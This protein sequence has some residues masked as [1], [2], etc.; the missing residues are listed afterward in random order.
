MISRH[1]WDEITE[2]P[3]SIDI[4]TT[5][6]T[7][8]FLQLCNENIPNRDIRVTPQD[9]PWI[10]AKCKAL[11]RI[12]NRLY[13]KFHRTRK[14]TDETNWKTKAREARV[15]LNTARLDYNIKTQEKLNDPTLAPKKYWSIVKR[16]YGSKKGMGI[17]VIQKGDKQLCTSID[18]ATAF[19]DYFKGQQT[20]IEPV[21]HLLPPLN[22]RTNERINSIVST[23]EEVKI[24]LGN[25]DVGKAHGVDGVSARL[26]KETKETISGPLSALINKSFSDGTVPSSWKRANVSPVHKKESKSAIGN[27]RPISLLSTLAK[28]QERVVFRR[29]YDFLSNNKLLTPRNSGFKERDSAMCQLISIV[30]KIHKALEAGKEINMVFLDVSKAFDKVWHKGLLLK[31]KSNGIAGDLYHWLESYLADR[32]IRVVINGQSAEWAKTNAG[33]PQGSIL[34]PLLFLVFI[35]DVVDDIE[36]D[37]NL[38]ADDTSLLNVIDQVIDSYDMVNRDLVK[39]ADW[40]SQW[41]VTFNAKKR[42]PYT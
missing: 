29:L 3:R 34:G 28:V 35:N 23:P 4:K 2:S 37:V 14:D 20:L 8:T 25:L 40:A 18:K 16:I 33:V 11:I 19:T 1:P 13:K 24:I 9:L 27:Y 21:G 15:A 36:S 22:L 7:E 39:L 30:D 41:L 26:L 6:W 12:R 32:K 42:F 10:T 17:P 31:L 38:F 5:D